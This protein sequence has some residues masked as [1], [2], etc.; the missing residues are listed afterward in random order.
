MKQNVRQ[1]NVKGISFSVL[2]FFFVHPSGSCVSL[3]SSCQPWR[4]ISRIITAQFSKSFKANHFVNHNLLVVMHTSVQH[5]TIQIYLKSLRNV[6]TL[7]TRTRKMNNSCSWNLN[8]GIGQHGEKKRKKGFSRFFFDGFFDFLVP[9]SDYSPI[10][11]FIPNDTYR[12][13]H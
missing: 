3:T 11:L 13:S 12:D 1:I 7:E 4:P 8:W 9:L 10:Y 5:K 6:K 2:L